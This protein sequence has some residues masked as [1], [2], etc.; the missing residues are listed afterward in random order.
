VQETMIARDELYTAD[1]IFLTGTAAEITPVREIDQRRVGRGE[2][3]ITK[4]VQETFFAIVK[5]G[6]TK[7]D[8]WLH[9][10]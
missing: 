1:E 5:G 6:D 2:W 9:F 8:H 3:T 4:N 10:V 7:H